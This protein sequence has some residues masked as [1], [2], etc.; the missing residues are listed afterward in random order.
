[1][2][3][4]CSDSGSGMKEAYMNDNGTV[5]TGTTTTPQGNKLLLMKKLGVK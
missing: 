1:M 2:W 3:V 4:S 5:T